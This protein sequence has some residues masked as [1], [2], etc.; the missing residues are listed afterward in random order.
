MRRAQY[1]HG[2]YKQ[3]ISIIMPDASSSGLGAA[4][5]SYDVSDLVENIPITS[6][7][8]DTNAQSII[9]YFS[10]SKINVEGI[11][12][13]YN[14][15]ECLFNGLL[16]LEYF[17]KSK[18]YD[19]FFI[20]LLTRGGLAIEFSKFLPDQEKGVSSFI[21]RMAKDKIW[22]KENLFDNP[23]IYSFLCLIISKIAC[24]TLV[25][26]THHP[27]TGD[28]I[29][30]H[31]GSCPEKMYLYKNTENKYFFLCLKNGNDT[32][33][34]T[35][36]HYSDH[37]KS[38]IEVKTAFYN[39]LKK[40]KHSEILKKVRI[41]S[42]FSKVVDKDFM[43]RNPICY[44]ESYSVMESLSYFEKDLISPFVYVFCDSEVAISCLQN[45][46][47][48]N[49]S[50]KLTT[51]SQK[52]HH[53]F[54]NRNLHFVAIKST[55]NYADYISRLLPEI[56]NKLDFKD[57]EPTFSCDT[58][59]ILTDNTDN[60]SNTI[61]NIKKIT[62]Y[63]LSNAKD[64]KQKIYN[65]YG[66]TLMTKNNNILNT[67][68]VCSAIMSSQ[69]ICVKESIISDK[70][71]E[72]LNHETML[73]Q[74]PTA[75]EIDETG[76][77]FPLLHQNATTND[78]EAFN[79]V[80]Y[81]STIIKQS[82]KENYIKMNTKNGVKKIA[83]PKMNT[84]PF[85]AGFRA[86]EFDKILSKS[87][88]IYFQLQ[89]KKCDNFNPSTLKYYD[90]KIILPERLYFLFCCIYHSLLNH[91]GKAGLYRYI[92]KYFYVEKKMI[93]HNFVDS[94]C[95]N[96]LPCLISKPVVHNYKT[97]SFDTRR[98][99]MP[100]QLML[101]DLLEMP[102]T[103]AGG[104]HHVSAIAIMIDAYSKYCQGY[105]I[106]SKT[107]EQI[108]QTLTNFFQSCGKYEQLYSDNATCFKGQKIKKFLEQNNVEVIPASA[109]MSRSHGMIERK[110][111][112]YQE[113][114]RLNGIG[115]TDLN[116]CSTLIHCSWTI[117]MIPFKNSILTPYNLHFSSVRNF[118]SPS[119][120]ENNSIFNTGNFLPRDITKEEMK[121]LNKI[122]EED[123]KN[124][125]SKD[126][127]EKLK[128]WREKNKNMKDHKYKV[129]DFVFI[130]D[131]DHLKARPIFFITLH[132]VVK[133]N[134]YNL[135]LENLLTNQ[136]IPRSPIQIKKFDKDK[137][138]KTDLPQELMK[139]LKIM[140]DFTTNDLLSFP[141]LKPKVRKSL[142]IPR[143]K[144]KQSKDNLSARKP[145]VPIVDDDDD[146]D[147]EIPQN[148]SLFD[149]LQRMTTIFEEEEQ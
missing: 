128:I 140:T 25:V 75:K 19:N 133:A 15:I 106:Y 145:D 112:Q 27:D 73:K 121:D 11:S 64:I 48:S 33:D 16:G 38:D 59:D 29:K 87:N 92:I 23:Y 2:P 136:I 143:N 137:I 58:F 10:K 51:L 101:I 47:M 125:K 116:I 8:L 18:T 40:G 26:L 91:I 93:L 79:E 84:R 34:K 31:F 56:C 52:I 63:I 76:K 134:K 96:C 146:N 45:N 117:N 129:G 100:N 99:S 107:Q 71:N 54:G 42:Y 98:L 105:V 7:N 46:K 119:D 95:S 111:R 14:P 149:Q 72:T 82:G 103:I 85:T 109:Y 9:D 20:M 141:L 36:V 55:L 68:S 69:E 138:I 62:D 90:H 60:N 6:Y 97:A 3:S 77:I 21:H 88:F 43:K 1:I 122:L 110:V 123:T 61:K 94:L 104:Q 39:T 5:I 57:P 4:L 120:V 144:T 66:H 24:R 80:N 114:L 30:H 135:W 124:F 148:L 37:M 131:Y 53:Y 102:T 89:E 78:I 83:I 32:A 132:Q 108:I 139:D 35:V 115:K 41:T 147:E 28:I 142:R 130:K 126:R 127:T 74:N 22:E 81:D 70:L 118:Q 65:K 50:N 12:E 17:F 113:M 86:K 13:S 49:R 67:A 44:L